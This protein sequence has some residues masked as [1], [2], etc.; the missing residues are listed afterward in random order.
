MNSVRI[1]TGLFFTLLTLTSCEKIKD[2]VPA[3]TCEKG[4]TNHPNAAKYAKLAGALLAKGVVGA[5]LTVITPQGTW[6]SGIGMADLKNKIQMTPCHTMRVGSVSKIFAAT[7]ILKLQDEGRLT[8][9]DPANRYL[10][11]EFVK[12]IANADRTTI[13]QLLNH[14]SGIVEYSSISNILQI[15]NLSVVKLSAEEN[16]RSIFGRKAAFQVGQRDEYSNSNYLLLSLIIKEVTG[17]S[18]YNYISEHI[19]KPNGYESVYANTSIPNSFTRAY[20]DSNDNGIMLDRTEIENNAVG[21]ADM[22]DG[23]MIANSY[24]LARFHQNLMTGQLL[25]EASMQSL[26]AFAPVTQDLGEDLTHLAGYSLG[27][28]KLETNH[29]IAIGHYGSVQS[30]NG[31]VFYFPQQEVTVALI[32]NSDSAK[33]KQ[34]VESKEIFDFLF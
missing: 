13:R 12:N 16:L 30:F 27:M 19:L 17:Q 8:L 22:V 5:S 25:S 18:A 26:F 31:M 9:D 28:M 11:S 14:T 21:G 1:I 7:A 10:P 2:V 33:I 4:N 24:D 23:G 34:F 15:L 20:Y 29:G 6:S 3:Q 32:R